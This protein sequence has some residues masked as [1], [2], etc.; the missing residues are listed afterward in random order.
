MS[1][2]IK[3]SVTG[4]LEHSRTHHLQVLTG[5]QPVARSRRWLTVGL[6]VLGTLTFA[7]A[8]TLP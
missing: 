2:P 8:F 5:A 4:Q 6:A 3:H 7:A 1:A